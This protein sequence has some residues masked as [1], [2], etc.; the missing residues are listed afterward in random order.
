MVEARQLTP[1]LWELSVGLSE[2]L[3]FYAGQFAELGLEVAGRRIWRSYSMSSPPSQDRE[4]RFVIKEIAQGAFSGQLSSLRPGFPLQLRGPFGAS[5]LRSGE[6]PPLGA[7]NRREKQILQ[8][9]HVVV[10]RADGQSDLAHPV[11]Y[12]GL[13][14]EPGRIERRAH[15][16]GAISTVGDGAVALHALDVEDQSFEA[17]L[18][19][20]AVDHP[21]HHVDALVDE[22]RLHEAGA[23]R[24]TDEVAVAEELC[25]QG[26][27]EHAIKELFTSDALSIEPY[28]TPDFA[29][30]TRGV[31]AILAKGKKWNEMEYGN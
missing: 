28:E 27:F 23:Q 15:E 11:E 6:R 26:Q 24:A 17:V 31:D 25:E 5:Y 1:E 18:A 7:C 14:V 30:E 2:P 19:A 20:L 12:G 8:R 21:E 10:D 16:A 22:N 3:E 13:P 29:K 4:L 9:Q